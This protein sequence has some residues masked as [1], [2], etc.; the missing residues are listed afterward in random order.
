MVAVMSSDAAWPPENF[1]DPVVSTAQQTK[2]GGTHETAV[3]PYHALYAMTN[4]TQPKTEEMKGHFRLLQSRHIN[5][6][7]HSASTRNVEDGDAR[8][9]HCALRG[10]D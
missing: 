2:Q 6:G 1:A 3:S 4:G 10:A 7:L 5:G 8:F 9:E